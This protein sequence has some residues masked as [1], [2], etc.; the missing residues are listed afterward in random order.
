MAE[1]YGQHVGLI[2]LDLFIYLFWGGVHPRL[3]EV[4]RL[5]VELELQLPVTATGTADQAASVT[6]T[7]AHG[8]AGSLIQ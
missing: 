6:Y 8:N 1:S 4:L 3:M 7:T 5:G 2:L